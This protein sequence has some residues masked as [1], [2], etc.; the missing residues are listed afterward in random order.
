[1]IHSEIVVFHRNDSDNRQKI[2]R[3]GI[4][5]NRKPFTKEPV[6]P[7]G[8]KQRFN[9]ILQNIYSRMF[10]PCRGNRFNP[11]FLSFELNALAGKKKD[12]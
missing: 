10:I 4:K 6:S 11:L 5:F 9:E 8:D 1:M 2:A 7:P 3:Q 12:L